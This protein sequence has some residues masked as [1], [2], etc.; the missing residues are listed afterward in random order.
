MERKV[1][2]IWT[3]PIRLIRASLVGGAR[4]GEGKRGKEETRR[5]GGQKSIFAVF[6]DFLARFKKK[7]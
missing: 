4:G 5:R 1:C 3:I 6:A 2:E 7:V